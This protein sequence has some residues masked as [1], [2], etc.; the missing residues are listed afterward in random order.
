MTD[1]NEEKYPSI[2]EEVKKMKKSVPL[3]YVCEEKAQEIEEDLEKE[4]ELKGKI[5]YIEDPYR[6]AGYDPSVIDFLRRCD[7]DEQAIE[8]I[9]YLEKKSEITNDEATKL[10]KQLKKDGL[11]SF[12]EK[13]E[14]G[15]YFRNE[16]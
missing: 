11:R 16:E 6:Y 1:E 14:Q 15:F 9:D 2:L 7:T 8:I 5:E 12:G 4:A 13:K 3:K 10:K